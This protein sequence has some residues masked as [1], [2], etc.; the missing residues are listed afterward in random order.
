MNNESQHNEKVHIF[1]EKVGT[2]G[3]GTVYVLKGHQ[4]GT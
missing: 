4:R 2:T 1:L 3:K